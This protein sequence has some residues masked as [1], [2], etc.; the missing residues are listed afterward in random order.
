V[1]VDDAVFLDGS[2]SVMLLVNG[3]W[4]TRQALRKDQTN[5]IGVGFTIK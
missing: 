1:G 3:V 2:D 4:L 5:T